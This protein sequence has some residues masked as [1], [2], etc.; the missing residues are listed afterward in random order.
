MGLV[1]KDKEYIWHPFTQMK[2]AEAAIPI[3]EDPEEDR[4]LSEKNVFWC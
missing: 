3:V 2:T 1:E 4:V